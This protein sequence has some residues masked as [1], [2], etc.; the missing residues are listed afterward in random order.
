T[1]G[2]SIAC[3]MRL[4]RKKRGMALISA[5]ARVVEQTGTEV[6]L[7]F[8]VAGDGPQRPAMERLAARLGVANSV[9]FLGRLD[10][11]GMRELF[12]RSDFFVLPTR[13]EAFGIAALEARAAGLPVVA[14][15]EGGIGEFVRDGSDGL[16]AGDDR[17]F[18]AH[19]VRLAS[20]RALLRQMAARSRATPVSFTWS[21]AIA[22]HEEIYGR[23]R[24]LTARARR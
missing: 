4:A 10:R 8:L 22:A 17:E 13:L 1:G 16:L 15:R 6:R 3:A 5:I 21:A 23:A 18:A 24:L 7:R 14:M 2:V 11:A 20:D 19:I 12:E 9:E